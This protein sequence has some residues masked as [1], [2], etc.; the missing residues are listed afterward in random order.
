MLSFCVLAELRIHVVESAN[1]PTAVHYTIL[2]LGYSNAFGSCRRGKRTLCRGPFLIG[3]DGGSFN[4]ARPSLNQIAFLGEK[5]QF[6]Q[7][8]PCRFVRR[9]RFTRST[10][11]FF[12]QFVCAPR[13]PHTHPSRPL[14]QPMRPTRL[15]RDPSPPPV[16]RSCQGV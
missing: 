16:P 14:L 7:L 3:V 6:P 10:L 5:F 8:P 12:H 4:P 11:H 1:I 2:S 13:L 9:C 15:T